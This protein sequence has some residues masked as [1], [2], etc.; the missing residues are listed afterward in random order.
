MTS[1]VRRL[2]A[3]TCGFSLLLGCE[4]EPIQV[5][6]NVTLPCG[7][8][9]EQAPDIRLVCWGRGVSEFHNYC[10]D[11]MFRSNGY[12]IFKRPSGRYHFSGNISEGDVTVTIMD[13]NED[14]SGDYFCLKRGRALYQLSKWPV[15]IEGPPREAVAPSSIQTAPTPIM[16][17]TPSTANETESETTIVVASTVTPLVLVMLTVALAATWYIKTRTGGVNLVARVWS[18]LQEMRRT[19]W[20]GREPMAV[21]SVQA[22]NGKGVEFIRMPY[23]PFKGP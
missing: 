14:D 3:W 9:P 18:L 5:G 21:Y 8:L 13:V 7:F 15:K 10:T 20:T 4:F 1:P 22:S 11:E 2:L 16:A 19:P 17:T 23:G 6:E 12:V